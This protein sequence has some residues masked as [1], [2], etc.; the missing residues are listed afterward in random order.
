MLSRAK[1]KRKSDSDD[2]W[3][4][5]TKDNDENKKIIF[6]SNGVPLQ[7]L[8]EVRNMVTSALSRKDYHFN[9]RNEKAHSWRSHRHVKIAI[10]C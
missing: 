10:S 2:N 6:D 9:A 4:S 1:R 8:P 3:N 7:Y 5:A